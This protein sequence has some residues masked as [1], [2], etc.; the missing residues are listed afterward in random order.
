ME[1]SFRI[2]PARPGD[3]PALLGMKR[4]LAR[5]ER[6]EAVLRATAPDWLR[7]GFGPNARF[8]SFVAERQAAPAGMITYSEVYLTALGGVVFSV[9]DLW[10][11]PDCRK[12]GMGAALMAQVAAAAIENG[13][14]LIQLSVHEGNPARRFYRR[15][16]FGHLR[17]CLT[18]AIG[19]QQMLELA[20]PANGALVLPR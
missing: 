15:L 14:P 7:D 4:A 10:V 18:Y 9:Q 3:V 2:R 8:R 11:E 1:P 5:A 19:G 17:E 13:I 12:L 20:L 6:N 16:G